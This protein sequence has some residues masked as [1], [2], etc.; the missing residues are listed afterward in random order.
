MTTIP[1]ELRELLEQ[2]TIELEHD[3]DRY[4]LGR[5]L[6]KLLAE[7][8]DSAGICTTNCRSQVGIT[9]GL[10]DTIINSA[11]LLVGRDLSGEASEALKDLRCDEDVLALLA[12]QPQAGAGQAV[13]TICD[14]D[15]VLVPR[16]LIGAACYAIDKKADAPEVLKNLRSY[17]F[18]AAPQP[19]ARHDQGD[20]VLR[21]ALRYRWIAE[22]A[23]VDCRGGVPDG[24][25]SS[26]GERIDAALTQSPKGEEE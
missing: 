13:P 7:P 21:D 12:E 20:E 16:G 18:V 14:D 25:Y 9:V 11:R 22:N 23:D 2:V 15:S 5:E 8:V 19:P 1:V 17:R 10:I 4:M 6:R 26:L 24:D 3:T